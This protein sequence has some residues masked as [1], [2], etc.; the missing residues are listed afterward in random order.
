MPQESLRTHLEAVRAGLDTDFQLYRSR[1]MDIQEFVAPRRGHFLRKNRNAPASFT[2]IMDNTAGLALRTLQSG[3]MAGISSPARPWFRLTLGDKGL[4][5][6]R[7]VKPWLHHVRDKMLGIFSSSNVYNSLHILYGELG[8]FGTS[9]IMPLFDFE[10]VVRSYNLSLGSY[11][12]GTNHRGVVDLIVREFPMTAKQLIGE[13]GKKNVSAVVLKAWED[14]S[15]NTEFTVIHHI[16]PNEN[17]IVHSMNSGNK[18]F[19]SIYYEEGEK[20]NQYLRIAGFDT[21]PAMVPRWEIKAEEHYGSGPGDFSL[22]DVKQLQIQQKRKAQGI[23]KMVNPPMQAPSSL[24][25]TPINSLPGGVSFYD[26]TTGATGIR[27]TYE[28]NPHLGELRE[29]INET[30]QR[31]SKAYYE[32]LFLMLA[33]SDR[34]QITAREIEE[35]HEEKLLMLGPVLERLHD[36]L[37]DPLI[38]RTFAICL[39]KGVFPDIP[40]ALEGQEIKV[41][42]ISLLAQAQKAVGTASIERAFA[43]T[44]NMVSIYPEARHKLDAT[45]AVSSYADMLGV[46]PEII[47]SDEEVAERVQADQ[48]AQQ[49][50]QQQE[51]VTQGA[52]NAKVLSE[53]DAGNGANALQEVI[54]GL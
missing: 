22:G 34:R 5:E 31:I 36:E 12:V 47:R 15:Y 46:P 35:R 11:K 29:D 43:F 38:D 1:W 33:N 9:A 48:Q 41:E 42:Y 30:Q 8:A 4:A 53:T 14:G 26:E 25:N 20:D 7:E 19:S 18:P 23:D 6:S 52:A 21:F 44:G 17:R 13:F 40:Q 27:P 28:V 49:Q 37:L 10:D 16:L 50:A 24:A 2:S 3:M 45:K 32:D 39:E 51:Q 54:G